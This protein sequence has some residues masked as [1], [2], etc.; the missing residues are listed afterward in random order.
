MIEKIFSWPGLG[1]LAVDAVSARDYPVVMG[2]V[3]LS[4]LMVVLGTLL[5]DILYAVVDPR[6]RYD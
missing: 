4:S 3:M 6:V 5:S 2:V 1:R